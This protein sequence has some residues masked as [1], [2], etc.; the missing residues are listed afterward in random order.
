ME[1]IDYS[2]T[3]KGLYSATSKIQEIDAEAATFL[4]VEGQ[5][6][7]KSSRPSSGCR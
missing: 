3:L 2:K 5:G 4:A 1:I 7:P 6:K